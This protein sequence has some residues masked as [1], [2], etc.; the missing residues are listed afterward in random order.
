MEV[1]TRVEP[2][3]VATLRII[4]LSVFRADSVSIDCF[5]STKDSAILLTFARSTLD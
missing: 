5:R 1:A 4:V 2:F 3:V